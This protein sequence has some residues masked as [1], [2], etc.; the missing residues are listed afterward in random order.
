M[1]LACCLRR[2]QN[3]GLTQENGD[4]KNEENSAKACIFLANPCN[5]SPSVRFGPTRPTAPLQG[6]QPRTAKDT[7]KRNP[8]G[9]QR[10]EGLQHQRSALRTSHQDQVPLLRN[11]FPRTS[12]P[13]PPP[14]ED[15]RAAVVNER[16]RNLPGKT[17][18][19]HLL[20]RHHVT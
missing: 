9:G 14:S 12:G 19:Q 3:D 18:D 5:G 8:E 7:R 20:L 16:L 6:P 11:P 1:P 13:R 17:P 2:R 15:V 10:K 4:T